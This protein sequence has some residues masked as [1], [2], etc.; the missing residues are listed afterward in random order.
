[1]P[2]RCS[3]CHRTGHNKATCDLHLLNTIAPVLCQPTNE[4]PV[5][6]KRGRGRPKGSKNKP[7]TSTP[8]TINLVS[9]P[10]SPIIN[11]VS[12]PT[13]PRPMTLST[14]TTSLTEKELVAII[15][16]H[17]N[18]CPEVMWNIYNYV[19]KFTFQGKPLP[20]WWIDPIHTDDPTL[21][22]KPYHIRNLITYEPI[23]WGQY[24]ETYIQY[25]DVN[26]Q[27]GFTLLRGMEV[28]HNLHE[29]GVGQHPFAYILHNGYYCP[30]RIRSAKNIPCF[31]M[32]WVNK[33]EPALKDMK[34][35]DRANFLNYVRM[36]T[37]IHKTIKIYPYARRVLYTMGTTSMEFKKLGI[38]SLG[39]PKIPPTARHPM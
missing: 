2:Y 31:H 23:N 38:N 9:P 16:G 4:V 17:F 20:V 35:S 8:P 21:R 32:G 27:Q 1:M 12:P 30:G 33:N 3:V 5:P 36:T 22:T 11:L 26:I 10:T 13:S 6:V 24:G 19:Y 18:M 37:G 28:P 14:T 29:R 34:L 7:K 39:L 15:C 25:P